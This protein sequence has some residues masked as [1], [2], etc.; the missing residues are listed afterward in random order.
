M[1][2]LNLCCC[3]QATSVGLSAGCAEHGLGEAVLHGVHDLLV[4]DGVGHRLADLG[5]VERRVLHVHADVLDAVGERRRHDRELAGFAQLDEI[6]V[7]QLVGNVGVAALEQRPP[8]AG[9]R[10][11]AP[12]DALDLG[13]RPQLPVVVA[14]QDD[15][16]AGGPFGELVGA[17][18]GGVLLGVLE[19]PGVLLGGV[20]LHQLGIDDAGHDDREIGDGQAVL[21]QE[22]D[23]HGVVVDHHEL[24][25]LGHRAGAHLEG[26]EAAD[27]D[28]AVERPLHVLGGDRRA[29]LELGV[30]AQLERG[31]HVADVHVL[32]QL[33]LE[34]VAV[35]VLHAVRQ[36]LHLVADEAVVAVP[37]HLVARH[38]GADAVDVDV[39]GT[40]LGDDQ[41]GFLARLGLGRR[42]HGGCGKRAASGDGRR[43]FQ[44]IPTLHCSPPIADSFAATKEQGMCHYLVGRRDGGVAIGFASAK[45]T[46][47]GCRSGRWR[48]TRWS[49]LPA[50]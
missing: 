2:V 18:A 43:R 45:S 5:I 29:V 48:E 12:D 27:G 3:G 19:P 13:L 50:L 17:A 9:R 11:H 46:T 33:H 4:G 31:G 10:H 36:R 34:L 44:E 8:V 20:L 35:V 24:L 22:V 30:L 16:G 21:L 39:V 1:S 47:L 26:G 49:T 7:G 38:V 14:L 25:G 40:A 32:G 15:L 37:R 23:A 28:G 6:L 42:P 41:Q